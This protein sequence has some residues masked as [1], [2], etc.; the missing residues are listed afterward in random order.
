MRKAFAE[1]LAELASEDERIVL[2]T[3]DLG[4][5]ALEP[6]ADRF[7]KRFFNVGVAEQN[8]I[9]V[10]TGLAEAGLIPFAYSIIPFAVL[11]PYE[12]IKNGPLIHRLPVR[13][14]GVGAGVD[15]ANNGPSHHGLDD[16]GVMR[17]QPG[18]M[19]VA[20]ADAA[21]TRSALRATAKTPGPIYFRLSKDEKIAVPP[22]DGR[23][24]LGRLQTVK[25]GKDV[26]LVAMGNIAAEALAACELLATDGI[27]AGLSIISS[28]NPSPTAD[29]AALFASVPLALTVETHYLAGGIGSLAAEVIAETG[30]RCRLVRCG[31]KDIPT[32]PVGSVPYFYERFGLSA[33]RLADNARQSLAK[34]RGA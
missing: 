13:I 10:A 9:G 15:Y 30:V 32:G 7:P 17:V 26:V 23:F 21:Q 8:M 33:A 2:L 27:S 20:P 12:F 1:T 29:L 25:E 34:L 16:V 28:L 22:L 19:V 4:Y 5:M 24:E 14:V 3:A 11:R 6:F 31:V 18:L